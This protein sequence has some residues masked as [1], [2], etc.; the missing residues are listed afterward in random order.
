MKSDSDIK[1]DV[2]QELK[3]DPDLDTTDIAI[4]VKNGVVTLTGFVRSYS[5]RYGA[6]RA[7]KPVVSPVDSKRKIEDAFKRSAEVDAK[8]V[9]VETSGGV[10]TLR[11]AVRSW[12]E[13]QEAER[14]AYAAPG[15]TKVENKITIDPTLSTSRSSMA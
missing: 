12:A 8:N 2:E 4:N 5:Q 13:R 3:W 10:A 15:V 11:G 1:R 6:E 14:A 9:T 7:A